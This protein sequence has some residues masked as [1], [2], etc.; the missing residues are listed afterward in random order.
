MVYFLQFS[1]CPA[2]CAKLKI[3]ILWSHGWKVFYPYLM[4]SLESCGFSGIFFRNNLDIA[5]LLVSSVFQCLTVLWLAEFFVTTVT[6]LSYWWLIF[7]MSH[8]PMIGRG[9]CNNSDRT[10]L[11]VSSVFSMSTVLCLAAIFVKKK[12]NTLSYWLAQFCHCLRV[13]WLAAVFLDTVMMT[14]LSYWWAQFLQCLA[15]YDCSGFWK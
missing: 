2:Y 4:T 8:S 10:L 7:S 15:C 9:F 3:C 13:L 1:A 12:L 14:A 11:L 6:A 5:L